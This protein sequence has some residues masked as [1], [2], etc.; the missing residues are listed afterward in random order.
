MEL[1]YLVTFKTI[2]QC[3]SFLEAAR[4]LN[5]TQSTITFQMQQLESELHVQLFEKIGR[6]MVVTQAGKELIPY[7]D[8]VLQSVE[9]M[10]NFGKEYTDLTGTLQVAVAETLLTYQMQPILRRFREQAPGVS[11]SVR[12]ENCFRIRD[13][14]TQG[15]VD[16]GVHYDVG[17]YGGSMIVQPLA[18]FPV[19]LIAA[20]QRQCKDFDTNAGKGCQLPPLL[21]GDRNSIY[22]KIMD[23][24][25]SKRKAV[26][27]NVIELG[28]TETVKSCVAGD[29]GIALLP[30]FTVERQLEEGTLQAIDS[31]LSGT[32][33]TAVC[34]YHKNKW[35]T[36]A[37]ELFMRLTREH[38]A[39]LDKR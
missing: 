6:K 9:Q 2:L 17:G 11:L 37:M 38:F 20:P 22:Q 34:S 8:A 28:N 19:T 25:L 32:E 13:E 14:I 18:K 10:Y 26:L 35:V 24:W 12:C 27:E 4:R 15:S 7:V 3:S 39:A 23:Q 36:P 5:Y 21:I 16:L 30:R 31:E 29:L 33:I 1:K